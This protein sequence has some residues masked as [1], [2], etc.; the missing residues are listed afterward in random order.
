MLDFTR[1]FG[2]LEV[3]LQEAFQGLAVTGFVAGHFVERSASLHALG[4]CAVAV[5]FF[6]FPKKNIAFFSPD[7]NRYS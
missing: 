7:F 5:P 1:V 2:L 3:P 4:F 6:E